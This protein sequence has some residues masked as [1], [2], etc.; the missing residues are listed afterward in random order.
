MFREQHGC[1]GVMFA[2]GLE[3]HAVI[4]FWDNTDDVA[5]L[6]SSR[7]YRDTVR[8]LLN[9]GILEGDQHVEVFAVEVG[10]LGPTESVEEG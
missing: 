1:R 9:S 5:Q 3:S 8:A 2:A 10:F 7:G 6:E 4:T